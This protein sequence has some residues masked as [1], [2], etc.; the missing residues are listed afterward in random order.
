MIRVDLFRLV[1]RQGKRQ[2]WP[3]EWRSEFL[4][5]VGRFRC[6]LLGMFQKN[7]DCFDGHRAVA[8]YGHV[9]NLSRLHQRLHHEDKFLRTLD[10]KRRNDHTAAAFHGFANQAR[11]FR[12]RV[13]VRVLPIAIRRFHYQHI[14]RFSFLGSGVH[15]FSGGDLAVTH[16]ANVPGKEQATSLA[17]GLERQFRHGRSQDVRR[18]HKSER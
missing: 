10:R 2:P 11:Q 18:V 17:V 6:V 9:R 12:T 7:I 5:Q 14:G 1:G 3:I 8:K 15:D 13:G 16:P 4:D